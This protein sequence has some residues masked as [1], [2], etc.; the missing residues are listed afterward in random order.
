MIW[1]ISYWQAAHE[2]ITI[3]TLHISTSLKVWKNIHYNQTNLSTYI[4]TLRCLTS[5]LYSNDGSFLFSFSKHRL[6]INRNHHFY[7][8]FIPQAFLFSFSVVILPRLRYISVNARKFF[9]NESES[10]KKRK[11][12]K[13]YLN[14]LLNKNERMS[15]WCMLYAS[16]SF[17][18]ML[19]C[20]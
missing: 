13:T 20:M 3:A 11:E 9:F 15:K 2:K 5:S 19:I 8:H 16:I 12:K 7:P 4:Y 10:K 14:L 18:F 17:Q 1:S 6:I